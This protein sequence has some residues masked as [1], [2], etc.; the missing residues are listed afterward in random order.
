MT[1]TKDLIILCAGGHARVLIDVL[2]RTGRKVAAL[3]DKDPALHGTALDGVPVVGD[4]SWLQTQPPETVT[5]V[6]GLGNHAK[7]GKS[8]LSRRRDLFVDFRSRGYTFERVI[9]PDAIISNVAELAEGAQVL[10]GAIVHP[11]SIIG[12]NAIINTGA[13]IDHDCRIGVHSH[14]APGAVLC[15]SVTV[16]AMCHIGAGAVVIEGVTIGD[17]AVIGAGSIVVAHVEP[18][19]TILGKPAM[20]LARPARA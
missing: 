17:G 12:D 9:S 14:I 1:T 11:G 10:T 6:N 5:L 20:P 7:V 16:G 8:G 3:L 2:H 18:R 19:A 4:E 13:Q 15:G